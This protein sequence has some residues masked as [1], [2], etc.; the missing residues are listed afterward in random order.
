MDTSLKTIMWVIIFI[1]F[2]ALVYDVKKASMYKEEVKNA[3]DIATKAATL[4][5]DKD[6]NKIAQGIFEIDP[7]A[8]KSA[9]EAYLSENLSTAKS[10]LFVY[11]IDYRAVNT[12]TLV[13]YTNPVTGAI[14]PIDHPTFIA[15]MK[16]TYK[17]IFTNQQIVIDNLSGTRLISTGN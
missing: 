9:F 1:I 12:H 2:S 10:D 7:V 17:G 3:L 5:V 11:V 6:P 8:S 13:N 15:V 4:Q 14:K 16:F